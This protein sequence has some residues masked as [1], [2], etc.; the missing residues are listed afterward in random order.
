[1][2][3]KE[4][5]ELRERLAELEHD[6]WSRW[7]IFM[8]SLGFTNDDT[9]EWIMSP[10]DARRWSAQAA[11]KYT[12]LLE[13][14]KDSE[15]EEAD[16]TLAIIMPIIKALQKEVERHKWI[17][18]D[19]KLPEEG[20][21]VLLCIN[22]SYNHGGT[23]CLLGFLYYEDEDYVVG[24]PQLKICGFMDLEE[25]DLEDRV[26]HWRPLLQPTIPPIFSETEPPDR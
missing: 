17:S 15:R 6:R 4:I 18:V 1:M 20:E 2:L 9:G 14:E 3:D 25:N 16:I 21:H 13:T 26:I 24:Q 23:S 11:T 8:F 22:D 10:G 12:G 7:M 19:D 5:A